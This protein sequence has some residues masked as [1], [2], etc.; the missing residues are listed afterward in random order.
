MPERFVSIS[1]DDGHLTDFRT[2]E[3]LTKYGLPATFY[4]PAQNPERPVMPETQVRELSAGFEIGAHTVSHLS[5]HTMPNSRALD[6]I[7]GGKQWLESVLGKQVLS[8]CYPQGKFNRA[9]PALV[10]QA[11]FLGARTCYFN[12]HG[13][14][15]NPFLW[16]VSTHA[17]SHSMAIQVRHALIE[18]NFAGAV[19]F[20]RINRC[21][22]DWEKHFSYSLD[23]VEQRGGIA[24]L[25]LHSWEIDELGQWKE[26][27]AVLAAIS[28][29]KGFRKVTNGDLFQ[30]W[31][32][33]SAAGRN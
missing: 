28:L 31:K 3:L 30:L 20:F 23:H 27:E 7:V 12:V 33:E 25:Y 2:A 15:G 8:F 9:T 24:H 21:E 1:V 11:G 29:R 22:T 16:G 6:E 5:L 17:Y 4:I 19:N 26:L 13:F 10:K 18:R 14:P 32:P